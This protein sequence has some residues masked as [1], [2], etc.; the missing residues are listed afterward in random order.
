MVELECIAGG[1]DYFEEGVHGS[2][3]TLEAIS[4]YQCQIGEGYMAYQYH[5]CCP[6]KLLF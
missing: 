3:D 1:V 5:M 4:L 2:V 6:C